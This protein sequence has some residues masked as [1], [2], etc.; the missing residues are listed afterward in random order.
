MT[1]ALMTLA[2]QARSAAGA[3]P[4]K[5]DPS[6][7][8][9]A[10]EHCR[11]MVR[12]GQL[13]HRYGGEPDLAQRAALA[14]AHFSLIEENIAL[15]S[16]V[17]EIHDG[18]MNSPTHRANMLN[19]QVDRVGIAVLPT[20]GVLYTVADFD[21]GVE[22]LKPA[23]VESAVAALLRGKG[24]T[25]LDKNADA[26]AYCSQGDD[27]PR[28]TS[29][30]PGFRMLW[31]ASDLTQL[32]APLVERIASGRYRKAAVGSCPAQSSRGAFSAYRVAVLLY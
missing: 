16:N 21:R 18:W 7:A 19:P 13:A 6:L 30:Q 23:E 3:P 9:A 25:I 15:G 28:S 20:N 2:N 27:A 1:E 14:G 22:V 10:L 24:L 31:Q 26:R 17:G 32:P 12:E 4:L 8:S 29:P 5:W 11:W